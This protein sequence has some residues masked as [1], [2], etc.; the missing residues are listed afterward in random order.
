MDMIFTY[1]VLSTEKIAMVLRPY[2]Y[3]A[4]KELVK[5]VKSSDDN[6]YIWHTTGSGKTLTSFKASQIITKLNSVDK[7]CFV[8]DRKDAHHENVLLLKIATLEDLII[9]KSFLIDSESNIDICKSIKQFF[10]S[11]K[12]SFPYFLSSEII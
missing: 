1:T 9:L 7:V 11:L 3:Y 2:Q 6:G 10:S 12:I 4:V 8:V 5:K